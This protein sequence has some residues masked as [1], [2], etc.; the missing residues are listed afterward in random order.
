M[1]LFL[2]VLLSRDGS[3][4]VSDKI[5]VPLWLHNSVYYMDHDSEGRCYCKW[6]STLRL[7]QD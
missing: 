6:L 5:D 3:F 2:T 4:F 1:E 7:M